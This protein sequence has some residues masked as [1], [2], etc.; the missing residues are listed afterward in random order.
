MIAFPRPK[1]AWT[2]G[3]GQW[4]G[5]VRKGPTRVLRVFSRLNIGGP[6]HHVVLLS[7]GL[8]RYGYDTRLVVGREAPHEG[9]FLDL[10]RAHGVQLT[11]MPSLGRAVRPVSDLRALAAL[12]SEIR[13][14]RPHILHTHTA[15]AGF[16]GRLAGILTGVPIMV[17]T[18]HGHVLSG[19]FGR[20]STALYRALEVL[21]AR[22][23][24]ALI[25][26]SRSVRDDLLERGVGR[27]DQIHV[28][29]LGL[30]LAPLTQ[31]LPR[32]GLRH[33]SGTPPDAPLVGIVGRLVPIK[34]VAT[35]LDA[36]FSVRSRCQD[37]RFAVVGDG[38]ERT[39]LEMRSRAAGLEG[40]VCFHGWRRDVR[41]VYGDLDVVVNCSRNEGTPVALIE[42]MAAGI[43]VVATAV[44]GTPDLLA[45][46]RFGRLVPPGE[47]QALADAILD[48]I[49]S[50]PREEERVRAAREHVLQ[51]H[52]VERLLRDMAALYSGL[53]ASQRGRDREENDAR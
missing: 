42:A 10:A 1:C 41:E 46:G 33:G 35:F 9:N 30:D 15:K 51:L 25:T 32:N 45:E 44:G 22:R 43:P 53:L 19:Y 17:H 28:I 4:R 12:V 27:P 6:S 37:V 13:A 8:E 20:G 21:L 34:D 50:R 52:S 48:A 36:A 3:M 18:Y 39:L 40:E 26:V 2:S 49:A 31:T 38:T 29:P 24:S 47:P 14:F 7:S 23:T 11:Q 16:L 5:R